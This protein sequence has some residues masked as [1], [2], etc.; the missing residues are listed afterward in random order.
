MKTY[1]VIGGPYDGGSL[2]HDEI[3]PHLIPLKADGAV[4]VFALLPSPA[5]I[6]VQ[7]CGG[8]PRLERHAYYATKADPEVLRYWRPKSTT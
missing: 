8:L 4:L 3:A 7:I 1:R 5:A 6:A 2:E